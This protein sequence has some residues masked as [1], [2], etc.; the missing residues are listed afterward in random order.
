LLC[1]WQA[2]ASA[3]NSRSLAKSIALQR[4]P[5]DQSIFTTPLSSALARALVAVCNSALP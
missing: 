3:P 4:N 1:A 2:L 5:G